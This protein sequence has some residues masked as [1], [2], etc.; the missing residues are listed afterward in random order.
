MAP[1]DKPAVL[2]LVDSRLMKVCHSQFCKLSLIQFSAADPELAMALRISLE[3]HRAR[4]Q[5]SAASYVT[6]NK[7]IRLGNGWPEP[8]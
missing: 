5:V 1:V 7:V 4:Q 8:G 2:V 6:E 3:E